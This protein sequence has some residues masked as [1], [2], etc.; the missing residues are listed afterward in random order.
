VAAVDLVVEE[1]EDVGVADEEQVDQTLRESKIF[2]VIQKVDD[3]YR[4]P[5][6]NGRN[7]FFVFEL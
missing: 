5:L 7:D 6:W 4:C 2:H 3:A 1:A